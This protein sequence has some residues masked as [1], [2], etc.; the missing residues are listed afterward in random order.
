MRTSEQT[1]TLFAALSK[2]Q[3]EFK[4]VPKKHENTFFDATY[5]DLTDVW[6][7]IR[8]I[9]KEHGLA[10]LQGVQESVVE[11]TPAL[12]TTR[13][14]HISGQWIEDDGVPLIVEPNSKDKLTMQSQGSAI[15]YARRQGLSAMLG[16][17]TEDEDDDAAQ[18]SATLPSRTAAK[19]DKD[20][21]KT[22]GLKGAIKTM[23]KLKEVCRA[24]AS[25]IAACTDEEMLAGLE[26]A[27]S[28]AEL[29]EQ[30]KV[31]WPEAWDS[32][33]TDENEFVGIKQ[34]FDEAREKLGSPDG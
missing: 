16:V 18:A 1:H 5:A 13:I 12:L 28:T 4:P 8:A 19:G 10:V 24:V 3:A 7:G 25:D 30:L 14:C 15:S 21:P 22:K 29:V 9:L 26:S 11:S 34:L 20:A 2:A 33:R 27:K 32:P 23:T 6:D 17:V 31:D